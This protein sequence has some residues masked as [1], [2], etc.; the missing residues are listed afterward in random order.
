MNRIRRIL[1][2]GITGMILQ[3][4]YFPSAASA[5]LDYQKTYESAG[6]SSRTCGGVTEGIAIAVIVQESMY[7]VLYEPSLREFVADLEAEGNCVILIRYS[8]GTPEE[9]RE[10]LKMTPD[11]IGALLVGDIPSAYYEIENDYYRYYLDNYGKQVSYGY[12]AFPF[13]YFY[14]DLDAVWGDADRDGKYD[15]YDPGHT[16][17]PV[18]SPEIWVGRL[19]SSPL[20]SGTMDEAAFLRS[21]FA[22]NHAYRTGNEEV[23]PLPPQ[24][25]LLMVEDDWI[26][27]ADVAGCRLNLAYADLTRITDVSQTNAQRYKE[28]LGKKLSD[29]FEWVQVCVH[30][31]PLTHYFN[32]DLADYGEVGTRDVDAIGPRVLFY[33]LF[34][35]SACRY[36]TPDYIGGHYVFASPNGLAVVGSAKTGSMRN[37][38]SFY[39]NL[40]LSCRRYLGE[41]YQWWFASNKFDQSGYWSWIGGMTLLGDPTLTLDPPR[42]RILSVR[43]TDGDVVFSGEGFTKGAASD[44][45]RIVEYAWRS[46]KDGFL[47]NQQSFSATLSPGTHTIYLKVRDNM[48]AWRTAAPGRWSTEAKTSV[49]VGGGQVPLNP[50]SGL[51]ATAV[52]SSQIALRWNDNSDN[53][54]GFKVERGTDG[55]SFVQI[56]AAGA[57]QSAYADAG[58]CANTRYYYRVRAYNEE[59]DSAYCDAVSCI[60]GATLTRPAAPTNLVARTL[61]SSQISL[62][63]TDNADNEAG[64]KI[65]RY[66]HLGRGSWNWQLVGTTETNGTSFTETGLSPRTTYY[67]IVRAFN[68]EGDSQN[69]NTAY[70]TTEA[71]TELPDKPENLE[72][73]AESASRIR[74]R[75]IFTSDNRDGFRVER[76]LDGLSFAGAGTA[77]R[78]G[79]FIDAGLLPDTAYYYRVRAFNAAGDGPYSDVVCART[80]SAT[81]DMTP[82]AGL[83]VTDMGAF[84]SSTSQ[85]SAI[86]ASRDDESG[87]VQYQYRIMRD[88][89]EGVSVKDWCFID[90]EADVVVAVMPLDIGATYYFAVRAQNGAG[91]WSETAYSDGITVYAPTERL[92]SPVGLTPPIMKPGA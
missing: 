17:D 38:F 27:V 15:D 49:T 54:S 10:Y 1:L 34:A 66:V 14:M 71:A 77:P 86:I 28:E 50:P 87:V 70:A 60:S 84:T 89:F 5:A 82:P 25:A 31:D 22:K 85:L 35:C 12:C 81:A 3:G 67:Y 18:L 61:S 90:G 75:W 42:A 80:Q 56:A 44:S 41:A 11:L 6:P 20:E 62:S 88:G 48:F 78:E 2:A 83:V 29:S 52:S 19:K 37:Y 8:G 69:S 57:G 4:M 43:H 46:D 32:R 36:D 7:D 73:T 24:K 72:A 26:S 55:I 51:T 79:D 40:S 59:G 21:Y 58:L 30:S 64:F 91:L 39:A 92:D 63:W 9:L 16:E 33:N 53:E 47:S 74:L 45:T 76:S 13:D 23:L 65:E 68:A